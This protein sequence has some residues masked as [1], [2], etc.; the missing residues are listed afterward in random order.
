MLERFVLAPNDITIKECIFCDNCI[1]ESKL[2]LN[3]NE[4]DK[5]CDLYNEAI[6]F[7]NEMK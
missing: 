2:L 1:E 6:I 3:Q 7:K 5:L 4:Y